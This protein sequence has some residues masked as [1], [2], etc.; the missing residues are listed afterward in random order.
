MVEIA[1]LRHGGRGADDRAMVTPP[2]RSDVAPEPSDHASARTHGPE[3][4][5]GD[6]EARFEAM[7]A[8]GGDVLSVHDREGVVRYISPAVARNLGFEPDELVGH[9]AIDL[10][11][12]D[13][14][15]RVEQAF[16][17]Q[18]EDA[19]HP[20]T[21]DYRAMHKDGSWRWFTAICRDLTDDP[22]VGGVLLSSRNIT[23]QRRAE[24]ALRDAEAEQR[25]I[26]ENVSELIVVITEDGHIKGTPTGTQV[27]GYPHEFGPG[28]NILHYVH[29][30]D[31]ERVLGV[32]LEKLEQPGFTEP[33]EV[34][35]R[36]VDG[37]WRHCEAI[38][39]N[40][41]HDP[42]V[43][44]AIITIRDITDRK[45][46]E[47]LLERQNRV[48]E[49]VATSEPFEVIL[50]TL[51]RTI[52]DQAD[53]A[54][55]AVIIFGEPGE[56]PRAV[57]A[58]SL[59]DEWTVSAQS[60]DVFSKPGWINVSNEQRFVDDPTF[61]WSHPIADQS[62]DRLLGAVVLFPTE[63]RFPLAPERRAVEL[64]SSLGSIA[65]ERLDAEAELAFRATH[66][67][68]TGL[69]TRG[70]F[71]EHLDGAL[72]SRRTSDRIVAVLF[73]DLDR[74]KDVN[75]G[76]GHDTG[77]RILCALAQR[78]TEALRTG[79]LVA[80]FG[81]DEFAVLA[82]VEGPEHARL[83]AGRLLD[84]ISRPIE[85]EGGEFQVSA[86]IGIALPVN[87]NIDGDSLIRD[88][89]VAMYRAKERG[90][91]RAVLFDGALR[92]G[93]M[94]RVDMEAGL[95]HALE[96]DEFHLDYQPVVSVA[97]GR[98]AGIEALLR[99]RP[100]DGRVIPPAEFIPLAEET[101]LIVPIGRWV[102]EEAAHE[103]ARWWALRPDDPPMVLAV[104]LSARQLAHP[105]L[106]TEVATAID[107]AGADA[108][109]LSL[110]ITE[111]VLLDDLDGTLRV[112]EALRELGVHLVIDDFGT[113]YSSLEYLK[114][115]PVDV[116]KIDRG[117]VAGLGRD[118]Q[119][120]AIVRA[121]IELSHALGLQVVAEGVEEPEQLRDLES[122][123]CDFAQGFLLARPQ[124]PELID[125]L[126]AADLRPDL[127]VA[128]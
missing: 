3:D 64:A 48:L 117:F 68:L 42:F 56:E 24:T 104:N 32:L 60:V 96:R 51:V 49:M 40:L 93:M 122:F 119:D 69:P 53:N 57:V 12:P 35:L 50:E 86:S 20:T 99:W 116:L 52:E 84:E 77:D 1:W 66:D 39:N 75:D 76:L 94:A 27:L 9:N 118:E 107:A 37:G 112:L 114:R 41:L 85:S 4:L 89:D 2:E 16:T 44:G 38:G 43:Q 83:V 74:F 124:S 100:S 101:G 11:H 90:R 73:L 128:G 31:R 109:H 110:E 108:S 46:S 63:R 120:R 81:G 125:A 7:V 80:R 10:V 23:D 8:Y 82:H 26:L 70:T 71:L 55:A 65:L 67:P 113:G 47:M 121:V 15:S 91:A 106:V 127:G 126:L 92:S 34:R 58:P 19:R 21:V 22:S 95:R 5:L 18:L 17:A 72:S 36:H 54:R 6:G 111:S 98:V 115:L 62:S 123:G 45:Q 102:L 87:G 105:G 30:A 59:S 33:V 103:A 29:P 28:E 14:R 61:G 97:S 78:L 88:A 13:D 79:D 25:A